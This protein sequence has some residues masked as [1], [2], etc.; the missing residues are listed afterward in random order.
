[1]IGLIIFILIFLSLPLVLFLKE[2]S[3]HEKNFLNQRNCT[4]NAIASML[5]EYFN[6]PVPPDKINSIIRDLLY[7]GNNSI[8]SNVTINPI[9]ALQAPDRINKL[10]L[11]CTK[12][13]FVSN[14]S[15]F[16]DNGK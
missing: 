3:D 10:Q 14:L 1:M 2:N 5:I 6:N 4:Q 11:N 9:N 15:I 12:F 8:D 13:A 7:E 16:P